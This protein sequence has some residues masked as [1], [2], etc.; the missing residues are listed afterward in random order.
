M[1]RGDMY[2]KALLA[3]LIA[4]LTGLKKAFANRSRLIQGY[5]VTQIVIDIKRGKQMG[6]VDA[7][8]IADEI[9]E[10]EGSLSEKEQEVFQ[11]NERLL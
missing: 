10:L 11:L 1:K 9:E 8:K 4:E 7:N 2:A 3:S 5:E 6:A